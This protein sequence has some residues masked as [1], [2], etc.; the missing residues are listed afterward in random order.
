VKSNQVLASCLKNIGDNPKSSAEPTNVPQHVHQYPP[1]YLYR[2]FPKNSPTHFT[3]TSLNS[4]NTLILT[5]WQAQ[6]EQKP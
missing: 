6:E 3:P 2:A 5:K 1:H 4:R